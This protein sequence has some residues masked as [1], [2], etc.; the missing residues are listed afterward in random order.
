MFHL[1][2][3]S[4]ALTR[5]KLCVFVR[6]VSSK[7][8]FDFLL[9]LPLHLFSTRVFPL[10]FLRSFDVSF[11]LPR[12]STFLSLLFLPSF[13]LFSLLLH[14]TQSPLLF[15]SSLTPKCFVRA[16][17]NENRVITS[18]VEETKGKTDAR[19]KKKRVGDPR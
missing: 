3:A 11:F 5:L 1:T 13:N 8:R 6:G 15:F 9:Y 16:N 17:F 10:S 2:E 14:S 4:L 19:S 18:E 7:K 12:L